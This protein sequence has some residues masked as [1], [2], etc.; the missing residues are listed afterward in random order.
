WH[1]HV[2]LR[3][4]VGGPMLLPDLIASLE[5]RG[6]NLP[7]ITAL[8][9][10]VELGDA[11][12]ER[13][14]FRHLMDKLSSRDGSR[15]SQIK[16]YLAAQLLARMGA[17]GA[18]PE[19]A[20]AASERFQWL[21]PSV[22]ATRAEFDALRRKSLLLDGVLATVQTLELLKVLGNVGPRDCDPRV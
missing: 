3:A 9:S 16:G 8:L 2:D 17:R 20:A 19:V 5:V 1:A 11:A 15:L 22:P 12:A 18:V 13:A 4:A 7:S 6:N 10:L 21:L 14:V